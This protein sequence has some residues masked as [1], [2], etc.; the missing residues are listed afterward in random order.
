MPS[1][2]E[3]LLACVAL[4]KAVTETLDRERILEAILERLSGLVAARNWTVYLLDREAGGLRFELVV[5]LDAPAL[6][7][8]VIPLG[9]G[10]AGA[11]AASGEPVLIADAAG[12]ARVDRNVD[13]STG[14]ETRS[15]ITLPLEC[16]G[17]VVGVLQIVNPEDP[18]LFEDERLPVL[19]LIADFVAIALNN[20]VIHERMHRLT[21]TDDVSGFYN[22]RFLHQRLQQLIESSTETSLVFLDMDHFKRIVDSYGHPLGGKVLKEVAQVIG[23]ELGAD[24]ALVRYG[25]DEY[26]IVLPGQDKAAALRKIERVRRALLAERFLREE[27]HDI[28]VTASFGIA[29]YPE[30]AAD[31]K[32]LLRSADLSLYTSKGRGKNRITVSGQD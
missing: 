29:H 5:G 1:L 20:A 27:G 24:D 6:A 3:Q 11:V 30:D 28:E 9:Q 18:T 19:Q 4:G 17:D 32:E 21:L 13:R 16:G 15:L 14:F 10:I 7:G 22:A 26:V 25:G 12:D 23:A 8:S 31:V 2:S